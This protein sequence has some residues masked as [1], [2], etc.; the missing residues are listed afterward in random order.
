MLAIL[1][2]GFPEAHQNV[3]ALAICR[4]FAIETWFEWTGGLALGGGAAINGRSLRDAGDMARQARESLELTAAALAAGERV[5]QQAVDLM[6][7]PLMPAGL[8]THTAT[9]GWRR[10]AHR[11]GSD[12]EARP[13]EESGK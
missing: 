3:T 13:F 10:Q 9:L 11:L 4:Q 12:L 1:N 8:Y 6:A 5:P 7:K 2:S